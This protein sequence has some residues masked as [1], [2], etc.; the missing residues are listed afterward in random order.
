[1]GETRLHHT[2]TAHGTARGVVGAHRPT[3]DVGTRTLVG[4]LNLRD[5]VHEHRRRGAAIGPT[6]EHDPRFDS[7]DSPGAIGVMAH[8]DGGRMSVYVSVEALFA[9]VGDANRSSG[10]Q[11]EQTRVHLQADVFAST[12]GAA[13]SAEHESDLVLGHSQTGGDLLSILVQPLSGDVQL[14]AT[15]IVIGNGQGRLQTEEGLI[16][17]ADHVRALDRDLTSHRL[18]AVD[19]FLFTED[20]AVG[21]NALGP[22]RD[23]VFGIGDRSQHFVVD[24]DGGERA[25]TGLRMIGGHGSH[26]LSDVTNFV[27]DAGEHRLILDDQ[28]VRQLPGYVVGGENARDS[29]DRQRG[30][31]VDRTNAGPRVGRAQGGSPQHAVG[32]HVAAEGETAGHLGGG[33][34]ADRAGAQSSRTGRSGREGAHDAAPASRRRTT[35]CCTASRMRPYPVQRQMLPE[36]ASRMS[37]SLGSGVFSSR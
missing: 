24:D 19:H 20:V 8:P 17:H 34:G 6:V 32:P 16:L 12:E 33:V 21:M 3:L 14:D 7:H 37:L 1:M 26:R 30:R 29:V 18:V 4:A 10:S 31:D 22:S 13:D 28:A 35:T 36:S 23:A 2:E 5:A 27:T 9:V 15:A 25:S 11:G